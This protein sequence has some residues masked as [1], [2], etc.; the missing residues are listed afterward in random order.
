MSSDSIKPIPEVNY[1]SNGSDYD[2]GFEDDKNEDFGQNDTFGNQMD[3]MENELKQKQSAQLAMANVQRPQS[4]YQRDRIASAKMQHQQQDDN[5]DLDKLMKRINNHLQNKNISK[6]DFAENTNIFVSQDELKELFKNIHFD[7][8]SSEI[9]FLFENENNNKNDGYVYLEEFLNKYDFDFVHQSSKIMNENSYETH[10]YISSQKSQTNSKRP[11]TAYPGTAQEMNFEFASFKNDI[12]N[13]VEKDKTK[14]T[15]SKLPPITKQ[16]K[17]PQSA[18]PYKRAKSKPQVSHKDTYDNK[19]LNQTSSTN[20]A[21]ME[22][23][24][25]NYNNNKQISKSSQKH[26]N[27]KPTRKQTAKPVVNY[28]RMTLQK[29]MLENDML[30]LAIEKMDKEFQREC[31]RK[32]VRANE[33]AEKL[34]KPVSFSAYAEEGDN[35]IVCRVWDKLKKNYKDIT[36][37]QFKSQYKRLDKKMK[38]N[39]ERQRYNSYKNGQE[40]TPESVGNEF[41]RMNRK[42]KHTVI[43]QIL[44]E[45][46]ELKILLKKQLKA[47][48][49]KGIIDPSIINQNLRLTNLDD[50]SI[51]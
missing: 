50:D 1:N 7:L 45:S 46:L 41:F 47:L 32:M 33:F 4:K 23:S 34:K 42:D 8:S 38:L 21:A 35:I 20:Q 43:K 13:I 49:D 15:K 44:K 17:H 22:Q 14:K 26:G 12:L 28:L 3:Q 5:V 18:M 29:Q 31:V 2:D 51:L 10:S 16:I 11:A 19:S 40:I 25:S 36:L 30:H 24:E 9:K 37:K 6:S 48:R 27:N 39:E